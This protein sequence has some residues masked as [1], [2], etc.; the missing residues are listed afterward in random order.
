MVFAHELVIS[1]WGGAT[2]ISSLALGTAEAAWRYRSPDFGKPSAASSTKHRD[3]CTALV[4][5]IPRDLGTSTKNV[6]HS[7]SVDIS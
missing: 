4:R 3:E 1:Q 6:H 7:E 2:E 5:M